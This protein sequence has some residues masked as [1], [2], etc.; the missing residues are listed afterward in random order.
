MV[1]YFL[2]WCIN[3]SRIEFIHVVTNNS[4]NLR[5][6]MCFIPGG[7]RALKLNDGILNDLSQMKI[8]GAIVQGGEVL[9]YPPAIDFVLNLRNNN[10]EAEISLVTNGTLLRSNARVVSQMKLKKAFVS[11]D[12]AS[13]T[14]Y[15][16]CRGNADL[17]NNALDGIKM[18]ISLGVEVIVLYIVSK[19]SLEEIIEANELYSSIGVN[20]IRL[21]PLCRGADLDIYNS[22]KLDNNDRLNEILSEL[23]EENIIDAS[24]VTTH[25]ELLQQKM[26]DKPPCPSFWNQVLVDADGGV[27]ICCGNSNII[28]NLNNNTIEK[29]LSNDNLKEIQELAIQKNYGKAGCMLSCTYLTGS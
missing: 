5:C 13:N 15:T 12:A 17:F 8:N 19:P 2:G 3:L 21:D 29:I 25:G 16:I 20:K 23:P 6:P 22:W 11:M 28:G 26:Q 27:K 10:P 18:L 24:R 4:C 7:Q 14:V 1:K 9:V